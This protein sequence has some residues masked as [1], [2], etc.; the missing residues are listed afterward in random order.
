MTAKFWL[1]VLTSLVVPSAFAS[2]QAH[3]IQS[4]QQAPTITSVQS[5]AGSAL[6]A[7]GATLAVQVISPNGLVVP[8]GIVVLSDGAIVMD[9]VPIINGTATLTKAFS[10]LGVHQVVACYSGDDNFLPSC[11]SPVTLTALAP[12]T[13]LQ[14]SPSAVIE[15]ST[16]FTDNLSVIPAKGFVG[17]VQ[18]VCQ[19]PSDQCELSPSSVSFSGDGK[20]RVVKASFIPS[21]LSPAISFIAL[22]L[23]GFMRRQILRKSNQPRALAI[24]VVASMLLGLAGCGPVVKIPFESTNFTMR[25]DTTSGAYSQAVMYQIQVNTDIAKQ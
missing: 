14:S 6:A 24:L 25:V 10:S 20:S 9:S 1:I 13:L 3:L 21:P 22:P 5:P 17:V 7:A 8:D 19:V 4:V 2:T 16:S 11:S 23:I 15:G 12:Y 18:L